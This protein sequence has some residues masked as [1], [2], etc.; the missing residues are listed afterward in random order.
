MNKPNLMVLPN[1]ERH[2]KQ[3]L[4]SVLQVQQMLDE[5]PELVEIINSVDGLTPLITA[6]IRGDTGFKLH[7]LNCYENTCK[8]YPAYHKLFQLPV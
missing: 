2:L 8:C 6:V 5:R 3:K 1:I 4:E 7:P